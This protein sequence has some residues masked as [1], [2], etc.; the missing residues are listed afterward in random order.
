M[1]RYVDLAPEGASVGRCVVLPG[2][3]YTAD[4]PLL[5]FATQVALDRGWDVRQVWW[6]APARGGGAD[7]ITWVGDQL[8]AAVGGYDGRVLVVGKSLGTLAAARAAA[9]GY[10]AA[11]L[12]PL[13][14][15]PDAAAPLLTYP[16]AQLVV[17]GSEDP[18]L[19][20]DV[21]DALPGER[22]VVAGDHVLRVP[23]DVAASVASHGL[24]ARMFDAWLAGLG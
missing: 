19:S 12:T 13:L 9:R 16:A 8:D 2:R 15:E 22:R 5:F 14:N 11:W 20:R 18:Y 24:V 6:E 17:I 3:Q 4:G 10:D 7:E 21:L 1:T 23:G